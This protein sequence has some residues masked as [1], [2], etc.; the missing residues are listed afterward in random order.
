[1]CPQEGEPNGL[2][3]SYESGGGFRWTEVEYEVSPVGSDSLYG[4]TKILR[5][6]QELDLNQ[7]L[8]LNHPD[9]IDEA[10][11]AKVHGEY[12]KTVLGEELG[13]LKLKMKPK[14]AAEIDPALD[15]GGLPL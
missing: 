2:D 8:H 4:I 14:K 9:V 6:G 11:A 10:I 7:M 3:F 12:S 5:N 13:Q 15:L 1:M